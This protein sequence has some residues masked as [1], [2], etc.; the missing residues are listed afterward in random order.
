MRAWFACAVALEPG[1][2]AIEPDPVAVKSGSVA[3][4]LDGTD[5]FENTDRIDFTTCAQQRCVC[6]SKAR[7]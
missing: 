1:A 4:E 2:V 5:D 3:M 6:V 7:D